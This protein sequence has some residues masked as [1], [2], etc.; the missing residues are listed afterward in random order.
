M[1]SIITTSIP[2]ALKV[3]VDA[4]AEQK[5]TTRS[6]ILQRALEGFLIDCELDAVRT[7]SIPEAQKRGLY[8][9]EDVFKLVS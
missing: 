9:D 4:L 6:Q 5:D 2:S 7:M 1:R 3:K 8:T